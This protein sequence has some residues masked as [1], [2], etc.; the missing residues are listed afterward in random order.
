[1][2]TLGLESNKN[3]QSSPSMDGLSASKQIGI[4]VLKDYTIALSNL[5]IALD[6][7]LWKI[8][9]RLAYMPELKIVE[10]MLKLCL[11]NGNSKLEL[12]VELKQVIIYEWHGMF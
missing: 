9:L 4:P 12:L 7:K 6:V 5:I 3:I 1:M 2:K 10:Q 11:D 8:I